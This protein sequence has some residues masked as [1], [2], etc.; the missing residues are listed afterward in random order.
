MNTLT[1]GIARGQ[2]AAAPF[3]SSLAEAPHDASAMWVTSADGIRLRAGVLGSGSKGTILLFQGRT[4]CLE[5]YGRTATRFAQAGYGTIAVD[6][7]GQG[8]SE[9]L[10]PNRLLGHV[11]HFADYQHDVHA[12]LD[13]ATS[14][15]MPRPWFLVAHSMGGAIGLRAL[16]NG[17][18]VSAAV[19][20]APLWGLQVPAP[21]LP[22]ARGL[23]LLAHL[24]GHRNWTVPGQSREGY[25]RSADPM[26]NVLTEDADM[27]AYMRAQLEADP[28]LNL[29]APTLWWLGEALDECDS[30]N[31]AELPPVPALVFAPEL[32]T[33]VSL[34]AMR[35]MTDRWP[36]AKLVE[37]PGGRHETMM[38]TPDRRELFFERSLELFEEVTG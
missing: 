38:E 34:D 1:E 10:L 27:L 25:I 9:R 26:N 36:S 2:R 3:L 6:F 37:I 18:P 12:L 22:V 14:R 24:T 8:R 4:E 33:I 28:E 17:F 21:L 15:D 35:Q 16:I 20:S 19:F 5:K 32:E 31:G 7:R 11:E 30:L 23:G 13:L 29:A